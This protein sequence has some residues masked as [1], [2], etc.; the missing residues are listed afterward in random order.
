MCLC[1]FSQFSKSILLQIIIYLTT[2]FVNSILYILFMLLYTMIKYPIVSHIG[3]YDDTDSHQI[4]DLGSTLRNSFSL[5][6]NE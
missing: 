3:F 2:D 4:K 5:W 6:S 1:N